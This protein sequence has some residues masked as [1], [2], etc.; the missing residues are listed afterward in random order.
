MTAHHGSAMIYASYAHLDFFRKPC[1]NHGN[2]FVKHPKKGP[3]YPFG[4]RIVNMD[5][6]TEERLLISRISFANKKEDKK[7]V[8]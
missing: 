5:A 2:I 3:L 4:G 8:L 7:S 1:P 6:I